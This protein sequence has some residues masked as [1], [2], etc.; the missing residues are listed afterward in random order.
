MRK[1]I[2]AAMA[3]AT[4]LAAGFL[5]TS[6]N[7]MTAGAPAGLRYA[8]EDTDLTDKVHCRWRR[9]HHRRSWGWWDGC[10]R[11]YQYAPPPFYFGYWGW[12]GPRHHR[13]YYRPHHYR[14][15]R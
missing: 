4:V 5:T 3:G 15:W 8:I 10:Y 11:G 14:R 1:L 2:L 13:H 6:V 12:G 7:A 9:P